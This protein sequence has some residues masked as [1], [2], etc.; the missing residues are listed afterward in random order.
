MIS[1]LRPYIELIYFV[2]GGPVLALFAFFALRQ[3]TVSKENSRIASQREAYRLASEQV[4]FFVDYFIPAINDLYQ[5]AEEN[6]ANEIFEAKVIVENGS[7][8]VSGFKL[9]K[10][11]DINNKLKLIIPP[12]SV[13]IN[14]LEAFSLYFVSG[15]AAETIAYSSVGETFERIVKRLMPLI[16]SSASGKTYDNVMKLFIMW[17]NRLEKEKLEAQKS[18]LQNRLASIQD[19]KITPVGT[20]N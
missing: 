17:H 20:K 9:S 14:R 4:R 18:D 6:N 5:V 12:Y 19:K 1:E 8:K 13:A 11:P 3:I 16:I 2:T 10:I 15:V 7:V